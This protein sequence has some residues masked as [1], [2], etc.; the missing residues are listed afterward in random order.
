M[1]LHTINDYATKDIGISYDEY[2]NKSDGLSYRVKIFMKD[3]P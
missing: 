1:P 3:N 2:M